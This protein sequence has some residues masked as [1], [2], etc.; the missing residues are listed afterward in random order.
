[1]ELLFQKSNLISQT[2]FCKFHIAF[3]G[4]GM[5]DTT[6]L[7]SFSRHYPIAWTNPEPAQCSSGELRTW[8]G[9]KGPE[10]VRFC[11]QRKKIAT[12]YCAVADD[13]QKFAQRK[14]RFAH[15]LLPIG[16]RADALDGLVRFANF[17]YLRE[18]LHACTCKRSQLKLAFARTAY[19]PRPVM[20]HWRHG[21]P[22]SKE[23]K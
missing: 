3:L 13:G 4:D 11:Q 16:A 19:F 1:V 9:Q 15:K 17:A 21:M 18:V 7:L 5:K 14:E 23:N 2:S 22:T 8:I 6:S 10:V 12:Q 20:R